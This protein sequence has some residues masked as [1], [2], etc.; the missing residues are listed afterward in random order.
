MELGATGDSSSVVTLS[1]IAS[2]PKRLQKM[3]KL[4]AK[5]SP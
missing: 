1:F 2:R 5:F 4:Q 3:H